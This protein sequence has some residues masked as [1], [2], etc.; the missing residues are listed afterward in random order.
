MD[1]K[2]NL[3]H[4]I[5]KY[6]LIKQ[7]KAVQSVGNGSLFLVIHLEIN[8][9]TNLGFRYGKLGRQKQKKQALL[10]ITGREW[11][12]KMSESWSYSRSAMN[13]I[14][15]VDKIPW[16][17]FNSTMFSPST[18]QS[19]QVGHQEAAKY[20]PRRITLRALGTLC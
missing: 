17:L 8:K 13:H 12:C 10:L 9:C 5:T 3:F 20:N 6:S 2:N 4:D 14:L 19:N 11:H 16:I 1:C 18:K 15:F 7:D